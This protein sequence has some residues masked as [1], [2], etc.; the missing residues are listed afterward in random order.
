M[1][2]VENVIQ[3]TFNSGVDTSVALAAGASVTS[4]AVALTLGAYAREIRAK[5]SGTAEADKDVEVHWLSTG[6]VDGDAIA[7]TD[8]QGTL[9]LT[10]DTGN[11]GTKPGGLM[12]VER[13]GYIKFV[14]NAATN[15]FTVSA[16][17][18][19]EYWS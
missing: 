13:D 17:I 5:I 1:P 14:N 2:S 8:N 11:P 7:D 18:V 19:E 15:S 4:D 16:V 10:L 9:V 3:V 6:D 12:T